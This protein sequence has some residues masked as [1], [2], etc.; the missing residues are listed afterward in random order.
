MKVELYESRRIPGLP[1]D[2]T[3]DNSETVLAGTITYENGVI[4]ADTAEAK[5]VMNTPVPNQFVRN[6]LVSASENP[7]QF[8]RSLPYEYR[9]YIFFAQI[10]E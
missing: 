5:R 7:E 9:N 8:L 3:V 2:G 6:T 1:T 10:L 4:H